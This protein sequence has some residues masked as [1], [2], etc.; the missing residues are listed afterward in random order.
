M[1]RGSGHNSGYNS[2]CSGP[3]TEM[4]N[5]HVDILMWDALKPHLGEELYTT[6]ESSRFNR[7]LFSFKNITPNGCFFIVSSLYARKAEE[8]E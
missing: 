2:N 4:E 8:G 3:K 5:A 7:P 1:L 6:A